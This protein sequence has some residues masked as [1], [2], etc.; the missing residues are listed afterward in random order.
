MTDSQDDTTLSGESRAAPDS[1]GSP[2]AQASAE[3][4]SAPG[5]AGQAAVSRVVDGYID[6]PNARFVLRYNPPGGAS[7][8]HVAFPLED[9]PV[10]AD[11]AA[12]GVR[13][14][15]SGRHPAFEAVTATSFDLAELQGAET[16]VVTFRRGSELPIQVALPKAVATRLAKSLE[17][18]MPMIG[19]SE[20]VN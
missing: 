5:S 6:A 13:E 12:L 8:G 15:L 16:I 3:S 10:L 18:V 9:L 20:R 4:Q 2:G 1:P 17:L 19:G 11:I 7:V 14:R